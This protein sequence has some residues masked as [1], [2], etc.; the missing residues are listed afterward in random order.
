MS[1]RSSSGDGADAVEADRRLA[2][3]AGD[4]LLEPDERAAA[5]EQDVR[6]V[7]G[8]VL[9]LGVLAAALR[10][11]VRDR[12]LE[13]LE[14]RLLHAF[15]RDVA[16]DRDVLLRAGDLV[17]LVDV[18]DALLGAREVEVGVLEQLE[19]DVLDVLAD[20]AGLGER[21]GVAD[22]ERHVEH[23]RERAREQRLAG[24]GRA[25]EQD[26]ALLDLDVVA[27]LARVDEALVVVVD[28]DREDLLRVLL[29]DHVLVRCSWILRG[30][31]T[32]SRSV[33]V[34]CPRGEAAACGVSSSRIVLQISTHSL[35]MLTPG[36]PAMRF[37]TR[38]RA[39]P[40]NV[41]R[42]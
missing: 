7:D 32:A 13:D 22:R 39:L 3:A 6:R 20:V 33:G 37:W 41:Q 29:A 28:R 21:R 40:Q 2:D 15:A 38:W 26:V 4:D 31:G 12:A 35:Q 30:L 25:D 8:D 24:A 36:G 17:D 5:D 9:L 14:Q 34:P 27:L 1:G 16:R 23:A 11:D 42:S 18:D 10:R 19:E